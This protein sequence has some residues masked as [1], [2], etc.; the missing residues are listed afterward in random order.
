M[1][2]P[3]L[4]HFTGSPL[5]VF[6]PEPNTVSPQGEYSPYPIPRRAVLIII[7]L[8]KQEKEMVGDPM[9]M[10]GAVGQSRKRTKLENL[11]TKSETELIDL[12]RKGTSGAFEE[13]ERRYR[14]RIVQQ[15]RQLCRDEEDLKDV[16]Q[17]VLTS[18]FLKI[19]TF[20]GR[21][22]LSTWIYRITMNAYLMHE[23]KQK[24]NRLFFVDDGFQDAASGD[25]RLAQRA[26]SS[27]FS[28][29]IR[30]ELRTRID[31]ALSELPPGYRQV[32][33]Y[34]KEEDMSLREVSKRMGLSV[35]A[36]K[37]RQH[38]AR[39]FLKTRLAQDPCGLH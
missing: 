31:R 22:T 17:D 38:R 37:S 33:L 36:V 9:K 28:A 23:R 20:Q 10:E 19:N 13:L 8:A 34:L 16:L 7:M 1:K 30:S 25:G 32:F 14:P 35:P 18:L 26:D 39:E 6:F 15:L 5:W 3:H 2:S 24:R 21:S 12:V 11:Q 27:P 29:M 4:P